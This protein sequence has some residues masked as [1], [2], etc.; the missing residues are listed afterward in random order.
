MPQDNVEVAI[1]T[2]TISSILDSL[3]TPGTSTTEESDHELMQI[4]NICYVGAGYVGGTNAAVTA[5]TNP[6][7][8]VN[9]VDIDESKIAHW[10]SNHLPINEA[11]LDVVVRIARDGL[12]QKTT[13]R[14]T[15]LANLGFSAHLAQ[16]VSEADMIF[17]AVSTPTKTFGQ[18]AGSAIDIA[19]LKSAVEIIAA[20]AKPGAI[21]VEKST[22]PCKTVDMIKGVLQ[23]L[24]PGVPFEVL[25]NPEFLTEGT[26]IAD[27]LRPSRILIGSQK[28]STGLAAAEKLAALYHWIPPKKI[29]QMTQWSAELSKLVSNAFLAQRISSINTISAICEATGTDIADVSHAIGLDSR[30][31]CDYLQSG[32]GFG[33]SCLKKDTL[34]LSYLAEALH[35]PEVASYWRSVIDV[36]VWQVDRFVSKVVESFHGTL[37]SEK[38]AIFGFAFKENTSDARDSQSIQVIQRLLEER[39]GRITIYDPGC[40]PYLLDIQLSQSFRGSKCPLKACSNPYQ[41]CDGA[42]AVLI[43]TPWA[44]FSYP[45]APLDRS[46]KTKVNYDDIL[47]THPDGYVKLTLPGV[48]ENQ[49]GYLKSGPACP[50]G[51][52]RCSLVDEQQHQGP[53]NQHVE[54]ERIVNCMRSPKWVFDARQQVEVEELAQLGCSVFSLGRSETYLG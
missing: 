2:P 10:N 29:L 19:D 30:I 33:G 42:S 13:G 45:P 11:G 6:E 53:C 17:L 7:I 16:H 44:A 49:E 20:E 28:T 46:K 40:D 39:P 22:V 9:V 54:W 38:L 37:R 24:R 52:S 27:L 21:I 32:L 51:C 36:N 41:A 25:S 3:S 18:G 12:Y 35:L 47:V 5:L 1:E 48:V 34:S 31:G 8:Q 43:L 50:G 26:A 14:S 4:S 23:Y 15:R